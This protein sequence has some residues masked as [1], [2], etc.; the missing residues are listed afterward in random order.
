LTGHSR[1]IRSV[2]FSP[3]G[4]LLAAAGDSST[5][6]LYNVSHGE[7]IANMGG[8]EGILF[9]VDWNETGE[10]LLSTSYE[11]KSKVWWMESRAC[12]ATQNDTTDPLF[13]GCWLQKGW[14]TAV[15]GGVNQG[16][17]TVGADTSLRWYRE[18]AGS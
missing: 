9:S 15:I 17:A 16:F 4:T 6:S 18:A 2:K 11:G 5:I 13:A 12:V 8:N 1:P 3:K 10:Y 7:L 14:G